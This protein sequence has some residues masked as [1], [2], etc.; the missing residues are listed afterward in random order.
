LLRLRNEVA[1]LRRQREATRQVPAPAPAATTNQNAGGVYL[2][3]GQLAPVGYATPEAALQTV[4]WAM[5]NGTYAQV[6]EGFGPESKA[7]ELR[8]SHGGAEQF[9]ERQKMMAPLFKGIQILAKKILSDDEV[10]LKIK[11]DADPIPGLPRP[12]SSRPT[13]EFK[14]QP[15]IK[16]GYEW[17]ITGSTRQH[18]EKWDLDGQV[19]PVTQ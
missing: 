3:K 5:M 11:M 10:E 18:E 8:D 9:A 1:Q 17:K 7:S 13:S 15:M 12:P 14:I 6:L 16:V 19:L 2:S 4:Y